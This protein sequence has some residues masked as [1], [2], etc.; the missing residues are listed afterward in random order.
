VILSLITFVAISHYR[1]QGTKPFVEENERRQRNPPS[2]EKALNSPSTR[3]LIVLLC[4]GFILQMG[5]ALYPTLNAEMFLAAA[6]WVG[7]L[8]QNLEYDDLLNTHRP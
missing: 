8:W 2:T 5:A 6:P 7:H 1:P 3:V 4:L